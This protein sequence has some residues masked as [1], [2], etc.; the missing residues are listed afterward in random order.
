MEV[1]ILENNSKF[2]VT[3]DE[4]TANKLL[5]HEFKLVSTI[6][7]VYT[8]VNEAPQ[9]FSFDIFDVKKIYFTNK[10]CL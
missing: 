9:N 6:G 10:L 1:F 8:F 7:G 3:K 2:I 5:T 4:H